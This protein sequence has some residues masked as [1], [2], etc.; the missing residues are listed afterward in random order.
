MKTKRMNYVVLLFVLF[1]FLLCGKMTVR[2]EDRTGVTYYVDAEEG[3]DNESGRSPEKAW[4]TLEKV[5]SMV[6]QPGDT[7]LFKAEGTWEGQLWPKGS[8]NE[9]NSII[10]DRY[11]DGKNL[12]AVTYEFTNE[13]NTDNI[14]IIL[15]TAENESYSVGLS[16]IIIPE[17]RL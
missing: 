1:T 4:K 6:F 7:I 2:A 14:K 10:I 15:Q 16:E 9:E 13:L 3:N 8:G 12:Y 5:N 11:G 17:G